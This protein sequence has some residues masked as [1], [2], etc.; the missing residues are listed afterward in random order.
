MHYDTLASLAD[1]RLL[2]P[3]IRRALPSFWDAGTGQGLDGPQ[4]S[5]ETS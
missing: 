4:S 2:W 3:L 5:I 1:D